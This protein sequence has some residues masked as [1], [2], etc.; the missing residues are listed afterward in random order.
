M[1]QVLCIN[2]GGAGSLYEPRARRLAAT[3]GADVTH[4]AV[5]RSVPRERSSR[6]IWQLLKSRRWDMVY[7]EGTGIAAG[8]NLIRAAIC[9]KQPFVVSS[10]DPIGG[11]F[12]VTRGPVISPLFDLYERLLYRSCSG[13][14]G[15]TPYLTGRAIQMGARRGVTV[16]GAVDLET[17]FPYSRVERIAARQKY[18]LNPD[19]LVCGVIGSLE[20][21]RRQSY[22]YGLELIE[23]LK[24]LKRPD[25]SVLIVGDGNGRAILESAVPAGLRS[26]VVF[27]GRLREAEVVT[28]INA[29]DIGFVAQTLDGLGSYRL[30]TKLP[31][32]LACSLPVAMSPVPG[33]Y[34]Y[35]GEAGWPLPPF[36]PASV[37][38]HWRCAAWLEGLA[39]DE[40]GER[41]SLARG[42]AS[43]RFGYDAVGEKF[44]RF[45]ESL[46]A[47]PPRTGRAA[48]IR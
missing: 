41:A 42:I 11:F 39:R 6:S 38:F 32:Y 33:F 17:F 46:L 21:V 3:L 19:H 31:E 40:V 14:V 15:W 7:L 20:W 30:T 2:T 24:R 1:S 44:C 29:M 12:Q 36:H 34:D 9:W 28:A 5:D 35:V 22:C 8:V 27:T 23:S 26:R 16:E 43:R 45:V 4:F 18:G 25:V 10:G 37:E 13:F 48:E 47:E